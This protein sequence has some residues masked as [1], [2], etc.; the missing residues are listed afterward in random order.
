MG[1]QLYLMKRLEEKFKRT[2]KYFR[3]SYK[4]ANG[5]ERLYIGLFGLLMLIY[6]WWVSLVF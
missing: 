6:A 5:R 1:K 2:V 4:Q 3:V